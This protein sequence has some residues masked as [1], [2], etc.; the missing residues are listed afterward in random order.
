MGVLGIPLI[1]KLKNCL[2]QRTTLV[3]LTS[4]KSDMMFLNGETINQKTAKMF[5]TKESHTTKSKQRKESRQIFN[6]IAY[7][8]LNRTDILN[9]SIYAA[10]LAWLVRGK[11]WMFESRWRQTFDVNTCIGSFSC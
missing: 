1:N 2:Q 5:E 3:Q 6:R 4:E 8:L 11:A 7:K 10:A 9:V